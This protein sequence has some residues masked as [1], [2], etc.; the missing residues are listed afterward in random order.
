[1]YAVLALLTAQAAAAPPPGEVVPDDG[2]TWSRHSSDG[3][4]GAV[5]PPRSAAAGFFAGEDVTSDTQERVARGVTLRRWSWVDDRGPVRAQLLTVDLTRPGVRL[6]HLAP[7]HVPRRHRVRR[8]VRDHGA[9]AGVNGDFFDIGD[10][11]APLGNARGRTTA[12]RGAVPS[13]GWT[14]SFWVTPGGEPRIGHVHL[15]ARVRGRRE[16]SVTQWNAPTVQPGR[17]GAYLPS[18]GRTRG[19][20]VVDGQRRNVREV[21]VRGGRVVANGTRL[22][23]GRL[24]RGGYVLVGRGEGADQL[25]SL[26]P[27][28]RVRL[29][30]Q[31]SEPARVLISGSVILRKDGRDNTI[32]DREMHPRTAV[33]I[34]ETGRRVLL[35][36]VDGRSEVSR[37][38]TMRETSELMH[39]LGAAWALNLDG[40]GSSTMVARHD[41]APAVV[42]RPSDGRQRPVPNGL[43]VFVD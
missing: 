33:G 20:A 32:D 4:P 40:G 27:G 34:D 14:K 22:S 15:L 3:E 41:G 29:D 31:L 42:N 28:R 43:G 24:I 7:A 6:D 21:L 11:G 39:R 26:R 30:R 16:V 18:W 37:G 8:L 5:A 9:V 36:V 19:G 17:V 38:L 2:E 1:M 12:L 35:L 10:T 13:D 25:R 23:Q